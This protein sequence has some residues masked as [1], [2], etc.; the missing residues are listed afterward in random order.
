MFYA[1]PIVYRRDDLTADHRDGSDGE[2]AIR[3]GDTG[4]LDRE[5]HEALRIGGDV[6]IDGHRRIVGPRWVT[7]RYRRRRLRT[8]SATEPMT[9]SE[10]A[11][12]NR[13]EE[14]VPVVANGVPVRCA[15][16]V[17]AAAT[18]TGAR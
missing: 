14:V 9:I 18:V 17:G 2:I 6:G 11:T 7:Y 1:T 12:I 8:P 10:P 15:T 5:A 16:R 13:S 4:R 3:F